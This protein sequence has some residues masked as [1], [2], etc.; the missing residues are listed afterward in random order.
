MCGFTGFYR[1][2]KQGPMARVESLREMNETM[3]HRGPDDVGWYHEGEIGLA[4]RRLSILDL[5]VRARQPMSDREKRFWIA[6]NG[7]IYNFE[8]IKRDLPGHSFDTTSDTEVI[9]AA[10]REWGID[11]L[12]RFIGMFA[13]A[14]YDSLEKKLFLARDR[15]GVKPL[16]YYCH[17]GHLAFAS[18]LKAL[19]KYPYFEKALD[20][21]SLYQYL[22]FQYIPEPRT[23]YEHTYKLPPGTYLVAH[24]GIMEEKIYWDINK[25]RESLKISE[26]D[27][28]ERL[29]EL[30]TDSIRL[31]QISDVPLGA[32]LSGGIDSST[33]VAFMAAQH[34]TNVKT[35][36]IGFRE[37]FY[38]EAPYARK[39]ADYLGTE[40]HELYVTPKDAYDVIPLLPLLYDEP[41]S[42]SSAIPTYLVSKMAREHVTVCL[43]GDGGDELFFGYNR[44]MMM[45]KMAF[46]TRLP[47]RRE[48]ISHLSFLPDPFWGL[49]G[50]L[51][52]A[53]LFR[54]MKT[55]KITP[56]RV[57]EALSSMGLDAIDLYLGL[58]KIWSRDEAK[59]LLG[60]NDYSLEGTPF[61]T[62]N[63][64]LERMKE[65]ERFSFIDMKTYLPGDILTK[66][67]RA[68]MAVGLE[69]RVPFLDHRIVEFA[70]SLP[71]RHKYKNKESKYLLKRLLYKRIPRELF[72]RPKQGFGIPISHWLS[73]D[74]K[75]L[76]DDY[77]DAGRIR[78]EGIFD[79]E[80]VETTVRRHCS[81]Q[82][83]NGYRLY[84]LLMFQMWKERWM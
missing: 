16:Y 11:C 71:F 38:D 49:V 22:V 80:F 20:F 27:Y 59:K 42:D 64:K 82:E 28:L 1:L 32:F 73:H 65:P 15:L 75:Y 5:S 25:P 53:L 48:L 9:L 74:L 67:D 62:I 2:E 63:E 50:S 77:L 33:I 35:F 83:D 70:C 8:E 7:E 57:R 23:I 78:K 43:S 34:K 31:R 4:H 76:M 19:V 66:V 12:H 60:G 72:Q 61:F 21:Q 81:G 40:H 24:D 36:S 58:V 68:S 10:F 79:H 52:Q 56:S 55:K 17:R 41:F 37:Q 47:L 13:F 46:G 84:N 45:K 54:S 30:L 29:E 6:Y 39:V 3:K 51:G 14:L 26:S 18:E 69:A 44:Y